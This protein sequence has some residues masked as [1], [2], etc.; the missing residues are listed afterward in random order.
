MHSFPLNHQQSIYI[1]QKASAITCTTFM[2]TVAANKFP[3]LG[4]HEGYADLDSLYKCSKI[5]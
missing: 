2:K 4:S 5:L 3:I 1:Q